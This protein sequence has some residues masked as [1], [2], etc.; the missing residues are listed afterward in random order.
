MAN[1]MSAMKGLTDMKGLPDMNA[2]TNPKDMASMASLS[3]AATIAKNS[4]P[5]GMASGMA[6]DKVKGLWKIFLK[7]FRMDTFKILVSLLLFMAY[8]MFALATILFVNAIVNL[9][10][11]ADNNPKKLKE[12]PI[13]DYL[14]SNN[15]MFLDTAILNFKTSI[16]FKVIVGI[17]SGAV[18]LLAIHLAV[19]Y[20]S[21]NDEGGTEWTA[22]M[23]FYKKEL[24]R[25]EVYIIAAI[26]YFYYLLVIAPLYATHIATN[27]SVLDSCL[28]DYKKDKNII[29]YTKTSLNAIKKQI[30]QRI[31][32]GNEN[33]VET[34][35]EA[36]KDKGND[37]GKGVEIDIPSIFLIYKNNLAR[38]GSVEDRRQYAREYINYMDEYFALL[39]RKGNFAAD[40]TATD[41]AD[42]YQA[43]YLVGLI[44]YDEDKDITKPDGAIYVLHTEFIKKLKD[45]IVP[46]IK[47]YLGVSI[48]LYTVMCLAIL[49]LLFA[50]K[51]SMKKMVVEFVYS[52]NSSKPKIF[53]IG[54]V[55]LIV[56]AL[57]FTYG[58]LRIVEYIWALKNIFIS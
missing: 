11:T 47:I 5:A 56:I 27:L 43:F 10:K 51:E 52:V 48:G 28:V 32:S 39:G 18:G 1:P 8:L 35:Y 3:T 57:G 38:K 20:Y 25:L 54:S 21:K 55:V 9:H 50:T 26:I 19:W 4:S 12:L 49:F 45:D 37:K 31:Y 44:E 15:F 13:F 23:N 17:V 36:Y 22:F 34:E 40:A 29:R 42:Y 58:I 30:Q 53:A 46:K 16:L 7:L 33:Y 6:L 14:K 2:M 24:R 41:A